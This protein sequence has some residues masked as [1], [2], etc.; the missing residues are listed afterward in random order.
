MSRTLGQ[1]LRRVGTCPRRVIQMS[2]AARLGV[3]ITGGQGDRARGA[4]RH[5]LYEVV[6]L[7]DLHILLDAKANLV[8]VERLSAVNIGHRNGDQFETQI[9]R[10]LLSFRG[11]RG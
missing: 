1:C 9:G 4:G 8:D 6:I 3:D 10:N 7:V 5:Q 2:Q 11:D